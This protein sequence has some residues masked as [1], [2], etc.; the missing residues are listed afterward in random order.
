MHISKTTQVALFAILVPA[1]TTLVVISTLDD[2]AR[3]SLLSALRSEVPVLALGLITL[4][5]GVWWIMHRGVREL[6][7]AAQRLASAGVVAATANHGHR[8]GGADTPSF[9]GFRDAAA[10]IDTLAERVERAERDVAERIQLEHAELMAERDRLAA[11]LADLD[12]SVIVCT[13]DGL[14]MLF[15]DAARS[16]LS[17]HGYLGVGR[18]LFAIAHRDDLADPFQ[19]ALRG[20]HVEADIRCGEGT[21]TFR[22]GPV[23]A[24]SGEVTGLVLVG[25]P[26][27]DSALRHEPLADT[28]GPLAV[29]PSPAG[30][31]EPP[32]VARQ[33][34]RPVS[35]DFRLLRSG[36]AEGDA[37]D[38]ELTECA[39]T[40]LD[41]ETTGLQPEG[42]DAVVAIGAVRVHSGRLREDDVLDQ[43]VDPGRR[44]P[45]TATAVHGITDEMVRG[46][47]RLP[48]VLRML[49]RFAADSVLVGHDIGFDLAF[50]GPVADA[51]RVPLPAQV[52]DVMLLSAVLHPV[53]D[54]THS[55]DTIA[56][57][58]GVPVLGRHTALGDAL[59]TGEILTRLL[60]ALA[61]IGITTLGEAIEASTSTSLAREAA[62]RFSSR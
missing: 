60:P 4:V 16:L 30:V 39:F 52:L 22:I 5:G 41:T 19:Q 55:L 2:A 61:A 1:V 50:L 38:T 42:G 14:T 45:A 3:T 51:E 18:S 57:R 37:Q 17:E 25:P 40:V 28:S 43:L 15:N 7:D 44:I 21:C 27:P 33:S 31:S 34:A 54:E 20:Q 35:Y 12:L 62:R 11:V 49:E 47:P 6:E 36:L 58:L 13:P 59:V 46:R 24:E 26:A 29:G 32:V 8:A 56:A 23:T 53:E 9:R 48:E 10:A